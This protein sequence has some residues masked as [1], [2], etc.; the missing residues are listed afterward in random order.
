MMPAASPTEWTLPS[1]G[2]SGV[3]PVGSVKRVGELSAYA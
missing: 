3:W 1:P 2:S